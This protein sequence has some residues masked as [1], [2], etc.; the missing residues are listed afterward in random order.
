ME[1]QYPK[2]NGAYSDR[3]YETDPF[4]PYDDRPSR[5]EKLVSFATI[6]MWIAFVLIVV[7]LIALNIPGTPLRNLIALSN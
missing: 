5:L 1:K 7:T 4:A 3:D 2:L 6:F